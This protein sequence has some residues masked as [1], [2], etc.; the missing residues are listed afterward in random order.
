M[1]IVTVECR[2]FIF[3]FFFSRASADFNQCVLPPHKVFHQQ[4]IF[5]FF[6]R[7]VTRSPDHRTGITCSFQHDE[8]VFVATRN[9]FRFI[10]MTISFRKFEIFLFLDFT[11]F[12][13]VRVFYLFSSRALARARQRSPARPPHS[14]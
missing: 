5:T 11:F 9:T 13:S 8:S 2:P 4:I 10:F 14:I 6:L 7:P 12:F 3:F 1:A